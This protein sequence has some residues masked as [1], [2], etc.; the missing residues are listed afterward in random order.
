VD[1]QIA[2]CVFGIAASLEQRRNTPDVAR[3]SFLRRRPGR[4]RADAGVAKCKSR[5]Q[6]DLKARCPGPSCR[7]IHDAGGR[8]NF[9]SRHPLTELRPRRHHQADLIVGIEMNDLA[10]RTRMRIAPPPDALPGRRFSAA[11]S[12]CRYRPDRSCNRPGPDRSCKHSCSPT[13]VGKPRPCGYRRAK[14]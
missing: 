10:W 2:R 14:A 13:E 11:T 4:A 3:R 9:P 1:H 12:R 6:G 7:G 5:P 8:M